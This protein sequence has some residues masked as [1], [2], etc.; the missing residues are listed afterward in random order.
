MG[1]LTLWLPIIA[2]IV[3]TMTVSAVGGLL[4]FGRL[5]ATLLHMQKDLERL[6]NNL[7]N[8]IAIVRDLEIRVERI[9][10]REELTGNHRV[11]GRT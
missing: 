5:Q 7:D 11:G 4:V 1:V 6:S 3:I 2:S 10:T 8:F 9:A